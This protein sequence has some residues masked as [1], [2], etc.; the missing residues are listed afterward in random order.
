[1]LTTARELRRGDEPTIGSTVVGLVFLS[2]AVAVTPSLVRAAE[3]SPTVAIQ[4]DSDATRAMKMAEPSYQTREE[5]LKAKPLDW[6]ATSGK[7]KPR[8]LTPVEREAL[9]T[10]RPT[11]A[12]GGAPNPKA[13]EEARRLHPDDWK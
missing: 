4:R 12:E 10:A 2:L 7:P 8:T 6:E 11:S 9:R 5:R 13:D 3:D 1:M